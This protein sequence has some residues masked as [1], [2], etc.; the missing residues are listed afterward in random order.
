MKDVIVTREVLEL[1]DKYEGDFGLL[2]ERWADKRDREKVTR[3]QCQLLGEYVE[4]LEFT[5]LDP[6]LFSA[7]MRESARKRIAELELVIDGEVIEILR[8]RLL[9]E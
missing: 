1:Y 8:R 6:V 3:E 5:R 4:K 7:E 2:H 9:E